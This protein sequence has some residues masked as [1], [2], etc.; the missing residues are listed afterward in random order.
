MIYRAIIDA[1]EFLFSSVVAAYLSFFY[2]KPI[3]L[4]GFMALSDRR[5]SADTFGSG[6][7]SPFV[8]TEATWWTGVV[9]LVGTVLL[10]SLFYQAFKQ[11]PKPQ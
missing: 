4:A 2:L 3:A 7:A 10:F 8:P 6:T 5:F 9:C 1:A 11:I